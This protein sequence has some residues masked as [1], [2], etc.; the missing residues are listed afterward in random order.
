MRAIE[1]VRLTP[2]VPGD[3]AEAGNGTVR[4]GAE[5][6][7]RSFDEA[8]AGQDDGPTWKSYYL[9]RQD[10]GSPWRIVMAGQG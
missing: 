6:S 7:L 1:G 3:E 4:V 5:F 9:R 10:A 8:E 2:E